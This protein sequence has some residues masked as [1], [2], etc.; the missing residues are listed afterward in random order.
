MDELLLRHLHG[1]TTEEENRSVEAWR[2][3]TAD[4]EGVLADYRRLIQAGSGRT[5]RSTRATRRPLNS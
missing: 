1:Q 4:A 2:I 5:G 3:R